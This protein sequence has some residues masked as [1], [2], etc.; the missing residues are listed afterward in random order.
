MWVY[1]IIKGKGKYTVQQET[2]QEYNFNF[3]IKLRDKI[4]ENQIQDTW[5]W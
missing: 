5:N 2:L 3:S 1:G 4:Q